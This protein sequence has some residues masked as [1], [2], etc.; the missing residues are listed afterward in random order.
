MLHAASVFLVLYAFW[1]LL[2]G[3]FTP[4]LLAAG[5]GRQQEG[6]EQAREQEPEGVQDEEDARGVEHGFSRWRMRLRRKNP[7]G[8]NLP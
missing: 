4:F 6:R 7:R 8:R 1:L 5:A 3:L 2:S